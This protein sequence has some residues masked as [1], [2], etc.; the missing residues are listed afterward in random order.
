M[1]RRRHDISTVAVAGGDAPPAGGLN[2]HAKPHYR[3]RDA[4][5]Q[6]TKIPPRR[7]NHQRPKAPTLR[8]APPHDAQIMQASAMAMSLSAHRSEDA[9]RAAN[10]APASAETTFQDRQRARTPQNLQTCCPLHLHTGKLDTILSRRCR[11]N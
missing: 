3:H 10:E 4:A 2:A 8:C 6:Y 11:R 5:H 7:C 9:T 1:L